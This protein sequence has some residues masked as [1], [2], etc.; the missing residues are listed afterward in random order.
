MVPGR[1]SDWVGQRSFCC[2]CRGLVEASPGCPAAD[3]VLADHNGAASVLRR[4]R[5]LTFLFPDHYTRPDGRS[6]S[7]EPGDPPGQE[8]GR[9]AQAGKLPPVEK[10]LPEESMVVK[11]VHNMGKYG[12]TW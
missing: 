10:R 11:P 6:L 1:Q 12:G 2:V 7:D 3:E 4:R 9:M 5:R 8:E